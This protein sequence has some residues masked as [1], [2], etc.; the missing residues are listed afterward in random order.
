MECLRYLTSFPKKDAPCYES[1]RCFFAKLPI[2]AQAAERH[3]NEVVSSTEARV[4]VRRNRTGPSPRLRRADR[5][6][7]RLGGLR[8][9][10]R[11][12]RALPSSCHLESPI[13]LR[14]VFS[15]SVGWCCGILLPPLT[16]PVFFFVFFLLK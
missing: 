9:A 4:G 12:L 2:S 5:A 1:V 8:N 6:E 11:E 7:H 10:S 14:N 13:T 3:S 15:L 16:G